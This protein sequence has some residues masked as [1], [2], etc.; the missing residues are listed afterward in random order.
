MP[1]FI[2][3]VLIA[4]SLNLVLTYKV[5]DDVRYLKKLT[6]R[7]VI[8]MATIRE[9]VDALKVQ[10]A[11]T[12]GMDKSVLVYLAGIKQQLADMVANGATAEELQALIDALEVNEQE[13]AAAIVANP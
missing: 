2:F 1:Y 6:R 8:T 11:E 7:G 12:V 5:F 4:L 13:M 3:F 9:T 10:V